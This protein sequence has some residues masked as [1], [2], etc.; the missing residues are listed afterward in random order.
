MRVL[1][2]LLFILIVFLAVKS[3]LKAM[4]QDIRNAAREEFEAQAKQRPAAPT[5]NMVACAHCNVYLPASEA[6]QMV[7]P[8]SQHYF[9]SEAHLK[10]LSHSPA[11]PD[12]PATHE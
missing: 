11:T 1:I 7:T 6:V 3:R 2:W 4:Q 9:C 10:A 8:S 12:S 5:E